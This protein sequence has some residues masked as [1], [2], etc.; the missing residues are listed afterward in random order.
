MTQ[1]NPSILSHVSIGSNDYERAKTFYLTVL[2]TL[3][4]RVVMEFPGAIAFGKAY[5]EFWVQKPYDQHRAS[6][7]NGTHIGFAAASRAAVDDFFKT[8][9]AAGATTDGDPGHRHEYGEP[10][11]GCFVRD[12]DG[13]KIE[14]THWDM[15]LAKKLGLV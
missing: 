7:G 1:D 3:G 10:Y 8:A 9:L 11:Y 12:L 4:I 6:V 2:P 13:H 5:P 14:A 15:E